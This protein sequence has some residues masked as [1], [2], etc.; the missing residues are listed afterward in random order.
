MDIRR[1]ISLKSFNTLRLSASADAFAEFHSVGE[2]LALYGWAAS[3]KLPI[4]VIGGGSNVLL[5]SDVNALVLRS[6]MRTVS[7]LRETAEHRIV[8]VDAGVNWHEWVCKSIDFGS[9]LENL[10]FIPGTV[11]AAPVQNIGAYGVEVSDCLE[12]VVGFCLS[13]AQLRMFSADQCR[14]AYRDSVFKQELRGDFIILRVL[15]RL[16]KQFSPVLSYGPVAQWAEGR[17]V[18]PQALIDEI[19]SIRSS[20]LPDPDTV[21]NAGSFFKNPVV[22]EE[23]AADLRLRYPDIPEYP[24]S[25]GSVKLAAGWLIE[26]SGWKGRWSGNAGMHK[27]QALVLVT[28]G[29]AEYDDL[30]RLVGQVQKDVKCEFGIQ[31][32]PEPQPF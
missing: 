26:R 13:T 5:T 7:V 4:K 12:A 23:V 11:G 32:E 25:D 3:H 1:N 15:F 18:T 29:K 2:L 30:Q 31:L 19:V 28:N 24:Q 21:P 22:C 6:A 16:R 14:F 27:D 17:E 20:K 8:S 9:G 10:A